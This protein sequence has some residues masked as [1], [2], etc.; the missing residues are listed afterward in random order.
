[1]D[2]PSPSLPL[3]H[4]FGRYTLFD[5]IGRGGMAEIYLA[6][7]KTD[8]GASR[9]AVIKLILP[10]Y[11][12]HKAFAD[13][14]VFE[15]KLAAR[16]DHPN[17][18][19]VF[20]LGRESGRLYIAMD[21]IEGIDLATLLR[22]CARRELALPGNFATTFVVEVLRGLDH[23]HR[24]TGDAGEALGVVHRDVSPSNVLVSLEGEVKLCDFGIAHANDA[25]DAGAIADALVGKAGYMAPEHARGEPVDA[26][27]DVFAAG[28]ILWELLSGRRMY[29]KGGAESLLDVARAAQI[30]A[31]Q[32]THLPEVDRIRGIVERALAPNKD[33][34]Y[35]TAA[36]FQR[37]LEAWA[38]ANRL[39]GS[40][41]RL[42]EWLTDTFGTEYVERRRDRERRV[43]ELEEE[44]RMAT[45]AQ[46]EA[47]DRGSRRTIPDA[48]RSGPETVIV[49]EDAL[50]RASI[51]ETAPV[52]LP[53]R[54]RREP[55]T[56]AHAFPARLF[57][58]TI[59]VTMAA[60]GA[61][62]AFAR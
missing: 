10:E 11:A 50:A 58:I 15:A 38:R 33:E 51:V 36:A 2:A 39:L 30:P 16:L 60:V 14:L 22:Q 17:V 43:R 56:L 18:V 52:T 35:P 21:Y 44:S 53:T 57:A 9:L 59:F 49:T 40:P 4:R 46:L 13:Q 31:F 27:A 37:D 1:M 62:L 8:S 12:D 29:R 34:R 61:L 5:F 20:D 28:V 26:R 23:A 7:V 45:L 6:R 55:P 24:R 32:A 48:P 3:P 19:Q 41:L 54:L 25:V 42:G 47:E